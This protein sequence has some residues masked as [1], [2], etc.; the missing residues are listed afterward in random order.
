MGYVQHFL[1]MLVG[2]RMSF[3]C[4]FTAFHGPQILSW[5]SAVVEQKTSFHRDMW[6]LSQLVQ[7]TSQ[8]T[9]GDASYI[10]EKAMPTYTF[11]LM[12]SKSVIQESPVFQVVFF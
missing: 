7:A 12:L 10:C 5:P 1:A 4:N 6:P 3:A 11:K 2:R 9:C 8:L